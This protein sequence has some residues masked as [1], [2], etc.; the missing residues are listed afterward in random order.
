MKD[1]LEQG[2][3]KEVLPRGDN[4]GARK[5][6]ELGERLREITQ[7]GVIEISNPVRAAQ[8]KGEG[9]RGVRKS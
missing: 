4:E 7:R 3:V 5:A 8:T 2:W 6:L 1:N 9:G